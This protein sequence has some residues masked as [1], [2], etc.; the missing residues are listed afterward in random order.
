MC[1]DLSLRFFLAGR[2]LWSSTVVAH[3]RERVTPGVDGVPVAVVALFCAHEGEDCTQGD[4]RAE[5]HSGEVED[6]GEPADAEGGDPSGGRGDPLCVLGCLCRT[7]ARVIRQDGT[8]EDVG[9]R[10][11]GEDVLVAFDEVPSIPSVK[12]GI[13]GGRGV[14]GR[15]VVSSVSCREL[16]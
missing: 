2:R 1:M 8:G 10:D 15:G 3:L 12:Y 5:R 4:P 11:R 13:V 14:A 9:D 6:A 16:A 7:L